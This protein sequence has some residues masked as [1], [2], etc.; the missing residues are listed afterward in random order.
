MTR[1]TSIK[2]AAPRGAAFFNLWQF[3]EGVKEE[4]KSRGEVVVGH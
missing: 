1:N 4:D 3:S 2:K